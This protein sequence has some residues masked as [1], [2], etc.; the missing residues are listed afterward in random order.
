MFKTQMRHFTEHLMGTHPNC[1]GGANQQREKLLGASRM[2]ASCSGVGLRRRTARSGCGVVDGES[3]GGGV[4]W[5]LAG[6]WFF[7][8][9]KGLAGAP[10][11]FIT[12]A[13]LPVG[14]YNRQ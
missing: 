12:P 2:A 1:R 7:V 10:A 4:H 8:E 5:R 9:Q 3:G 14:Y 13:S 6:V 11:P